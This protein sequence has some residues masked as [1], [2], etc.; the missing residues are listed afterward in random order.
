MRAG[1][2][3]EP[4]SAYNTCERNSVHTHSNNMHKRTRFMSP[5]ACVHDS[6]RTVRFA[7]S[8]KCKEDS[9]PSKNEG[10]RLSPVPNYPNMQLGTGDTVMQVEAV[11]N[12]LL[13]P[14]LMR[15]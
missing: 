13:V 2:Q 8:Y 5:C 11:R 6:A 10:T 14:I 15:K 1:K 3:I 12:Q 4:C 7:A 9:P